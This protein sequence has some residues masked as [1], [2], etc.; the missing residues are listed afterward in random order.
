M[1]HRHMSGCMAD[2]WDVHI[3]DKFNIRLIVTILWLLK[4][5]SRAYL[6]IFVF[7]QILI[8]NQLL[9]DPQ[10]VPRKIFEFVKSKLKEKASLQLKF[11]NKQTDKNSTMKENI[12]ITNNHQIKFWKKI[13]A[14]VLCSACNIHMCVRALIKLAQVTSWDA[15]TTCT[16]YT[17][18]DNLRHVKLTHRYRRL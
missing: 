15:T 6:K 5:A 3:F 13:T 16:I 12:I 8:K 18:C 4:L 11:T 10:K 1:T 17:Q 9:Q 7:I 2:T 14:L